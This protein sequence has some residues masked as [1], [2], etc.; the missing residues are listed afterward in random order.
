MGLSVLRLSCRKEAA[1]SGRPFDGVLSVG[2]PPCRL[3]SLPVVGLS[4][5]KVR[6]LRGEWGRCRRTGWGWGALKTTLGWSGW[7]GGHVSDPG[8]HG[9]GGGGGVCPSQGID[10]L[11]L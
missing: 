10:P 7:T 3:T 2:P 6:S 9:G 1:P 8:A 5:V 11:N 4:S